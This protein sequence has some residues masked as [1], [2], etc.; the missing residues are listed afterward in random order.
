MILH[1]SYYRNITFALVIISAVGVAL[2]LGI[3][4]AID[5]NNG[6][7]AATQAMQSGHMDS[8]T[9]Q[10]QALVGNSLLFGGNVNTGSNSSIDSATSIQ[11]NNI[12]QTADNKESA[13]YKEEHKDS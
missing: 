6:G 12:N 3:T 7:A 2:Q 10:Y 8:T 5:A 4:A 1:L 13:S 11:S 9:K